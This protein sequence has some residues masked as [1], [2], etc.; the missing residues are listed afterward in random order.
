MQFAPPDPGFADRVRSSFANQQ[1]MRTLAIEISRVDP[2]IVELTMPYAA[3]YTQ[4]HGF[5]HGGVITTA[6][7]TACGY[8]AFSLMPAGAAVLSVEFKTNLLAPA[9]G[10]RFTFRA[11]VVKPGRTLTVCEARAFATTQAGDEQLIATMTATLM[12]LYG[13]DGINEPPGT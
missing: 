2:G 12:A 3:A 9:K 7:D 10:Y 4:Q 6:L 5:M 8:A 1:A 11:Q 13:R